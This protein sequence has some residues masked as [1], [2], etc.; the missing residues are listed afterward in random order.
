[1]SN[2]KNG[3]IPYHPITKANLAGAVIMFNHKYRIDHHILS[4][5]PL[6][7]ED[8]ENILDEVKKLLGELEEIKY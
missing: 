4:H 8:V 6:S 7:A 1:M 3:H 2:F 5:E